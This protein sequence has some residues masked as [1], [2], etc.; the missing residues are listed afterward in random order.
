MSESIAYVPITSNSFVEFG[1]FFVEFGNYWSV[2]IK[3]S[4]Q[5]IPVLLTKVLNIPLYFS[6]V[7]DIFFV[8]KPCSALFDFELSRFM[9][10]YLGSYVFPVP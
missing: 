6:T 9:F 7:F 1:M 2:S 3:M 5:N 8:P 10:E 4:Q